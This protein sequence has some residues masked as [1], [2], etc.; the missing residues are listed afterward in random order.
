MLPLVVAHG[1]EVRLI[2]EDVRRHEGGVGE[3][4][5]VDVV[6]VLGGL[7]LELSH[8]GKLAEH[9][10]AVENPAQLGV[11][12]DVGLDKKGAFL[13]VQAA[14]DV[15]C[16]LLYG[17][18]AQGGGVLTDSDG[19]QIRHKEIAVVFLNHLRPMVQRAQIGA[20]CQITAGLDAG[21]HSF[22]L[23]HG[24]LLLC[25]YLHRVCAINHIKYI[26]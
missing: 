2:E 26:L 23:I 16:Q 18:P 10:I 7:I 22:F 4:P 6:G 25:F 13:R 5:A 14:G 15:L 9:G 17:A 11:L 12:V 20:Q 24:C 3:E 1:D 21:K 19:V 8:A